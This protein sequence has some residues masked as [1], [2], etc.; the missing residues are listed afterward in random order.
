MSGRVAL[1]RLCGLGGGYAERLR[2]RAA[3][4]LPGP[5]SRAFR[6]LELVTPAASE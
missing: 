6:P 5:S 2:R 4:V 1:R 3:V